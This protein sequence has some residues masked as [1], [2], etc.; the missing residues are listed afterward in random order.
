MK[1]DEEIKKLINEQVN[2]KLTNGDEIRGKLKVIS[3][4]HQN[5]MIEDSLG[6][7]FI[8]G[9]SIIHI[10]KIKKSKSKPVIEYLEVDKK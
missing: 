3:Q 6:E 7:V 2:V 9:S 5:V 1:F 10:R 4:V 8:R